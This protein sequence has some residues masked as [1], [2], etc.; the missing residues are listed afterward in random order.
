MIIALVTLIIG[1]VGGAVAGWYIFDMTLPSG[2][3]Y[4]GQYEYEGY[5]EVVTSPV[6]VPVQATQTWAIEYDF[7]VYAVNDF[8]FTI[9]YFEA[10]FNLV[11]SHT[12]YNLNAKLLYSDTLGLPD[13]VINAGIFRYEF[14][15][16]GERFTEGVLYC[17]EVTYTKHVDDMSG[18]YTETAICYLLA[19]VG[20]EYTKTFWQ[21]IGGFFADNWI[22]I[23]PV[24]VTAIGL[25]TTI[26]LIVRKYKQY[27]VL[28]K[29]KEI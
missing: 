11:N 2:F 27:K 1:L 19:D 14:V 10:P 5:S 12:S 24:G 22:I 20:S 3:A 4:V 25:G 7:D 8:V 13:L 29:K 16:S 23:L 18:Y 9:K 28:E 21:K 17:L 15:Y 6:V 26:A